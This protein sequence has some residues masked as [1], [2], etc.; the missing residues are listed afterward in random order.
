MNEIDFCFRPKLRLA[1]K[2][3]IILTIILLLPLFYYC[4]CSSKKLVPQFSS[5]HNLDKLSLA[6]EFAP[7]LHINKNEFFRLERLYVVIHSE[8]PI[9]AYHLFWGDD[10]DFPDEGQP[11]DHEI[12][13]VQY[14]ND[15][16]RAVCVWTYWHGKIL[17]KSFPK[18][19]NI[20]NPNIYIQ[21]GKH[22][23]L[24]P[25]WNKGFSFRPKMEIYFNYLLCK[26]IHR[27]N[28]SSVS[29]TWP[30]RFDGDYKDY[31]AFDDTLELSSIILEEKVLICVNANEQIHSF[32]KENFSYKT[33]WPD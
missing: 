30:R 13:W 25:N 26:Y 12:I 19:S 16:S 27:H 28:R 7:N 10:I 1:Y 15:R 20:K 4:S 11:N 29:K 32:Y 2:N 21:W 23:S 18:E 24:P 3:V 33:E 8:K 31:L 9:I 5:I 17:K 22:G 14:N 6:K